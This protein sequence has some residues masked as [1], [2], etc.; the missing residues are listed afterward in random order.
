MIY[1]KNINKMCLIC[2]L[3]T[4]RAV[5]LIWIEPT[6]LQYIWLL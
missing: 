5:K 3:Q 1:L 2:I 4:I 6:H